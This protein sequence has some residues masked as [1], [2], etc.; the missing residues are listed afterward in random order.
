MPASRAPAGQPHKSA[1]GAGVSASPLCQADRPRRPQEIRHHLCS[2]EQER[3]IPA[4]R[5]SGR[6]PGLRQTQPGPASSNRKGVKARGRG[7]AQDPL[8]GCHSR[9]SRPPP[10]PRCPAPCPSCAGLLGGAFRSARAGSLTGIVFSQV[11]GRLRSQ[12]GEQPALPGAVGADGWEAE[13]AGK[14]CPKV[15]GAGITSQL[16]SQCEGKYGVTAPWSR[17]VGAQDVT[18]PFQAW[19]QTMRSH[20]GVAAAP[21]QPAG[22]PPPAHQPSTASHRDLWPQRGP[23]QPRG[24]PK[25][26]IT[27][28]AAQSPG[29]LRGGAR[30][31]LLR[32]N[33]SPGEA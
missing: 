9:G 27:T 12:H 20:C 24:V 4:H 30:G 8:C 10:A 22:R 6:Q 31:H 28:P 17:P 3:F 15:G 18:A 29:L 7:P 5:S 16:T 2:C 13:R 25:D 1:R 23:T 32:H 33:P 11:A 26:S 14:A 21:C 19:G